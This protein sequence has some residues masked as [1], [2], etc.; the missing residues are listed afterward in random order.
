MNR[1][2]FIISGVTIS[3]AVASGWYF[4]P[5]NIADLSL[6]TVIKELRTLQASRLTFDGDWNTFQVF[7]HMAQSVEFSM[8]GYPEHRSDVFKSTVGKA[9]FNVFSSKGYMKH[10]LTE[11]IPGAAELQVKGS[12]QDA[13][14]RLVAALEAFDTFSEAPAEHFAYGSLSRDEYA[15]AH[16]LHIHDHLS[17][18][19]TT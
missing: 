8:L 3:A 16:A 15:I 12:P 17:L 19:R 5:K 14:D 18:M 10:N 9:A 6:P 13:L 2:T 1:R 11:S 7:T 4:M